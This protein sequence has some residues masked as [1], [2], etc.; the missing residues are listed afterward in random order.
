MIAQTKTVTILNRYFVKSSQ[1]V[2]CKV[3]NGENREYFVTVHKNGDTCCTCKH[4]ESAGRK[5]HCYHVKACQAKEQQR[6]KAQAASVEQALAEAWAMVEANWQ[7]AEVESERADYLALTH[8]TTQDTIEHIE[9]EQQ[10]E[11]EVGQ[12]V[13]YSFCSGLRFEVTVVG[14]QTRVYGTSEVGYKIKTRDWTEV[15]PIRYL[16]SK[17]VP[18]ALVAA[19]QQAQSEMVA[20][21]RDSDPNAYE[22]LAETKLSRADAETRRCYIEMSQGF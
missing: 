22:V 14:P 13:W 9:A 17:S 3:R 2:I 15:V 12:E 10:P 21:D 16:T 8:T 6:S 18:I 19:M 4:G 20:F 1:T 5:A 7:E 11:F